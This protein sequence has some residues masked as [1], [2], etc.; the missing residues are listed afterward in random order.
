MGE[1][2]IKNP[3]S[4]GSNEKAKISYFLRPNKTSCKDRN[5]AVNCVFV[6]IL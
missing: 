3:Y 4:E 2:L 1:K 5:A 6:S